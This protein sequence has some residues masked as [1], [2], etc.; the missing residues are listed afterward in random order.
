MAQDESIVHNKKS[1]NIR[2][3]KLTVL[4]LVETKKPVKLELV[5]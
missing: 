3:K 1:R 5:T 2:T 4:I